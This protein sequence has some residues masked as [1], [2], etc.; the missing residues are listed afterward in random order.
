MQTFCTLTEL[1]P[2]AQDWE[3]QLLKHPAA[4]QKG[5]IGELLHTKV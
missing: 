3:V 2:K 5:Q 4:R 1:V